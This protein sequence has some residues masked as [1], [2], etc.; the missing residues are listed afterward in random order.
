M[1]FNMALSTYACGTSVELSTKCKYL[2]V[3]LKQSH[4]M[5]LPM[6]VFGLKLQYSSG[7]LRASGLSTRQDHE[8]PQKIEYSWN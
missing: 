7:L 3:S 2:V 6:G 4:E 5:Q 1:C 8:T